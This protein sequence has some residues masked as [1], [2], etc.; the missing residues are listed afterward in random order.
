[1]L[2]AFVILNDR[3]PLAVAIV[4]GV[5]GTIV[6]SFLNVC[7]ARIPLGRS[8]IYPG[9]HCSCGKPI[10]WYDNLPVISWFALRGKCR[11]CGQPFSFRYPLVEGL[12]GV[13][14]AFTW[15]SY[16]PMVAVI[17]MFFISLMI[18]ATFV[19][20]DYLIIPDRISIGGALAGLALSFAV[21]ALHGHP[22]T[23]VADNLLGGFDSLIGLLVGTAIIYWIGLLGTIAFRKDAMG[24]GDMK[25]LACIGA[26]L[27]WQGAVFALF[28]GAVIGILVFLPLHF[29]S[30]KRRLPLT[31][32]WTDWDALYP[33]ENDK[34]DDGHKRNNLVMPFGPMLALGAV[35]YFL[36]LH[37]PVDNYFAEFAKLAGPRFF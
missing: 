20:W 28:G 30:R 21:P 26:F 9:S 25:L 17:G 8:V 23:H 29:F 10:G 12:T 5:F 18:V 35:V 22:G 36:W 16:P 3:F 27:G 34:E 4:A 6:G 24:E 33:A 31:A 11:P 19:D 14:F 2:D 32:F 15:F 37:G 13:L 7:I 1:M